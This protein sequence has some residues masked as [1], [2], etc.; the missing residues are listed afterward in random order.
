M[1]KSK[2]MEKDKIIQVI[3]EIELKK[4]QED[5]LAEINHR[6]N[7]DIENILGMDIESITTYKKLETNTPEEIDE[8]DKEYKEV[9]VV[10]NNEKPKP[11]GFWDRIFKMFG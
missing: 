6:K 5:L 1:F 3:S 10:E 7:S 11:L 9:K 2:Y 8:E 4:K